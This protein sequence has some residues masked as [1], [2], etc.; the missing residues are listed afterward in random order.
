MALGLQLGPA[1]SRFGGSCAARNWR[2]PRAGANISD[3][4]LSAKPLRALGA[5][6][7]RQ[8]E[9]SLF[10]QGEKEATQADGA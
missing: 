10:R 5:E 3:M 8:D 7:R 1:D 9:D 4:G 6:P 2:L